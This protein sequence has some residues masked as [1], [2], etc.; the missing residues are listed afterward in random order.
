MLAVGVRPTPCVLA[1][2]IMQPQVGFAL[3]TQ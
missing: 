2:P 3:I 1:R